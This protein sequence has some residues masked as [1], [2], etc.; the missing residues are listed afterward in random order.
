[1]GLLVSIRGISKLPYTL[2]KKDQIN[3]KEATSNYQAHFSSSE[4]L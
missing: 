3:Q 4:N 2:I 1:M